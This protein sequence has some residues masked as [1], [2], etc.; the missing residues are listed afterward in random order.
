MVKQ[1]WTKKKKR[2]QKKDWK[3]ALNEIY[4]TVGKPAALS[5]SPSR[6]L[7]EL[8]LRYNI[9]NVSLLQ[10]QDWL[11]G[12]YSHSVHKNIRVHFPRNPIIAPDIDYQWQGDLLFLTELAHFNKGYKVGLVIIDVVSRYA[13]GELMKNK[14]GP[15][16]LQAFQNILKR[17]FPRI[18]I[19]LQTDKGT[20]F[21]NKNFQ[22]MLKDNNIIFF[23]TE[24]DKKAA[25]AERF[26]QTLKKMIYKF[27]AEN[28]T[29]TYYTSFQ[30]LIDTYNNTIHSTIKFAPIDVSQKNL[31]VV[32]ENL[33]GS[34]WK[35]DAIVSKKTNF[36][37]GD[38]VRISKLHMNIFR[39]S[40][41]GN[42]SKEIFKI[43]HIKN[44]F[45]EV[46][47]GIQDLSGKEII[48]S[49]YEAEL[50][51]IP[52]SDA[53]HHYWKIEKILKTKLIDGK[54]HYF[55]KWQD[56]DD[57][58]NSWISAEKMKSSLS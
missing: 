48:G 16:T 29:K 53:E 2:V 55:V 28:N 17:S 4:T 35:T 12:K 30:K 10:I 8:N 42:W 37:P 56:F 34:L 18:P 21:L 32:M 44:T 1:R 26:I 20:E 36:K 54:K 45:G 3:A 43:S 19:K 13:W 41:K 58:N 57:S 22:A 51:K 6:L 9:K 25:I 7:R 5:S 27:L 50:Q 46:I 52:E 40:Y 33:Y 11:A 38:F 39:K 24:S 31:A 47:Y 49:F 23:T 15:S 14:S